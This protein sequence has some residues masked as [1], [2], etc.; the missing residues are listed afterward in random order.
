M[1]ALCVL[2]AFAAS[3]FGYQSLTIPANGYVPIMAPNVAPF[4]SLGDYRISFRL[5]GWS[6]PSSSSAVVLQ[7]GVM[8]VALDWSNNLCAIDQTDA[9]VSE[10]CVSL[11]GLSDVV[12]RVQKFGSTYPVNGQGGSFWLE[13]QDEATG[14]V[15]VPFCGGTHNVGCPI[16]TPSAAN[17]SGNFGS[18]GGGNPNPIQ[19]SVA[20]LKWFSATVAPHF[21][22]EAEQTTADLG[23]WRLE[24]SYQSQATSGLS[25]GAPSVGVSFGAS[26]M[27][28]PVCLLAR[29]IFR[30]GTAATLNNSSYPLD[31]GT[32]LAYLW[33][34]LPS[35]PVAT[36]P[37]LAPSPRLIWSSRKV[38]SPVV[39]G[40]VFGSYNIQLTVTD[41]S[42]QSSTCSVKDGFAATDS[43]NVVVSGNPQVATLVGPII[44]L[45]ANPW[46]WF[47]DRHVAEA[48]LQTANLAPYY[49]VVTPAS[50]Q[51]WNIAGPGTV[52]V[53]TNNAVVTG[54]GTIFTTTF[55]QGP[56]NPTTPNATGPAISIWYPRPDVPGGTGRR[57]LPVA[58]CQSDTQLT[59]V[60]PWNPANLIANG[61]GLA[62]SYID[63]NLWN[64]WIPASTPADYYDMVAALYALYY[65][66][67]I[68]DYLNTAR[69]FA[70][71]YWQF[72]LDSGG[73][74]YG[75]GSFATAN[76]NLGILGMVLRA[77][78]GRPD[79]WTG[80][81]NVAN[82]HIAL[83]H[84]LF[85]AFGHWVVI[86]AQSISSSGDP[87]ENG[88][89]LLDESY[90][91][92][93][94]PNPAGAAACR[95]GI[96]EVVNNG[97][98]PSRFSDGNFYS[99]YYGGAQNGS[100]NGSSWQ[101]GTAASLVNGSPTVTCVTPAGQT[102]V[103]NWTNNPSSS[104][105]A[106]KVMFSYLIPPAEPQAW[107]FTNVPN[108]PPSSNAGGDPVVYYPV[109]V[110]ATHITLKDINGNLAPYQ[111]TTG[112]HGWVFGNFVGQVGDGVQPY[113]LGILGT[114]FDF[115]AKAMACA[116]NGN[117]AGCSD[118][119]SALLHS[120]N[121]QT[122]NYLRTTGFWPSTKG[123]YYGSSFMECQPPVSDTNV[124]CTIGSDAAGARVLDAEALRAVMTAYA[125]NGDPSLKAFGDTLYTAMW[126]QPG[127]ALPSGL[128]SDGIYIDGYDDGF[129][130]FMSGTPP[131][132]AAHKY[133]GMGF[134]IGAG[135]AWPGYRV[136]GAHAGFFVN[137]SISVNIASVPRAVKFNVAVT[138]T[139]GESTTISCSTSPCS[140]SIDAALG[141]PVVRID[142]LS[143]SNTILASSPSSSPIIVN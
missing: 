25:L 115:S 71:A 127:W 65:R 35:S 101:Q 22:L 67:G 34:Q 62:Y 118:P 119:L 23:D 18:I 36:S 138:Y 33:Q 135:S 143:A 111:G 74:F 12:V 3:C 7:A 123:M 83:Y 4:T 37:A 44:R 94:D 75:D 97:W 46:A 42:G 64:S 89:A 93:F 128:T 50:A 30:A 137:A 26:P 122:A 102:G 69:T 2:A 5:H 24:G 41:G 20:Y 134:G 29:Q 126:G 66:S 6:V 117:P 57:W 8:R 52:T 51:P 103:C 76:R 131:A 88:Y 27:R 54:V 139:D 87:R 1:K 98:T 129:G 84:A 106:I 105:P 63:G 110:D 100:I 86:G 132:G 47:D 92:L 16:G 48:A 104:D 17:I 39:T 136:G 142:F 81:E 108:Q 141:S 13:A 55:C 107:W 91:A 133:F 113:M 78:D 31:G 15:L 79:M 72:R 116:P 49:N 68:D 19:I 80:I 43:N 121:V 70:D 120:Y 109:P 32:A 56:S 11:V 38:S 85:Q 21:A 60:Q 61:N 124:G 99:F 125:S 14:N 9:G 59:L 140:V 95:A 10:P 58:S 73:I 82:S 90:C 112:L 28:P 53:T 130:T 77:L 114:A 40:G 45:Y 96:A